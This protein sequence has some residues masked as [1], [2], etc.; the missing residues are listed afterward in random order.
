MLDCA[1]L[2]GIVALKH[3]RRPEVEVQGDE[4]TIVRVI[5]L[6]FPAVLMRSSWPCSTTP[7]SVRQSRSHC[8]MP[9]S[10]SPLPSSRTRP[11]HRYST[12]R[13]L[14]RHSAQVCSPSRSTRSASC[15]SCK[16]RAASR[17]R[18]RTCSQSW[19]SQCRRRVSS[20]G[21][22]RARSKLTGRA[23]MLRCADCGSVDIVLLPFTGV[24]GEAKSI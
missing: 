24:R 20:T 9:R 16:R 18:L 8:I 14:K 23:G 11:P 13:T 22:L 10:V 19:M 17:S 3:F 7:P 12:H 21:L 1:C 6:T 15:A 5:P 4:V 2:A